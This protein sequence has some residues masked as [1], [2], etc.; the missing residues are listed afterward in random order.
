MVF[1]YKC[2][3][4]TTFSPVNIARKHLRWEAIRISRKRWG[5]Y[6][7]AGEGA[8]VHIFGFLKM[9]GATAG[10]LV[11]GESGKIISNSNF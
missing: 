8:Q 2:Y 11:D 7:F 1:R 6:R 3:Y 9:V 10:L 4:G 5:Y